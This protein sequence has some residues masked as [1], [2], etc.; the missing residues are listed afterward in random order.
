MPV[1]LFVCWWASRF[2]DLLPFPF[3]L[4]LVAQSLQCYLLFGVTCLFFNFHLSC[5]RYRDGF[6]SRIQWLI[7]ASVSLDAPWPFGPPPT[8]GPSSNPPFVPCKLF[9]SLLGFGPLPGVILFLFPFPCVR[10]FYILNSTYEWGHTCL[11]L[12]RRHL[13]SADAPPDSVC[14]GSLSEACR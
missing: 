11:F 7:P 9:K 6:R 10:L 4:C 8:H 5:I 1:K 12:M 14:P 3:G 13:L 2:L